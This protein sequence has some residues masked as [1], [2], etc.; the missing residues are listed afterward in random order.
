V[1]TAE[2]RNLLAVDARERRDLEEFVRA[3]LFDDGGKGARS[4]LPYA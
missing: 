1:L 3:W 4:G 2:G